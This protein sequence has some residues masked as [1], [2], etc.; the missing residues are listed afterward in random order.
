MGAIASQI[1]SFTVVYSIVY[2]DADQRKYESSTSLAFVLA[3][4]AGKPVT[5]KIFTFQIDW[6]LWTRL[7]GLKIS[8][9]SYMIVARHWKRS[10]TT[11][12]WFYI[13]KINSYFLLCCE[14]N[15]YNISISTPTSSLKYGCLSFPLSIKLSILSLLSV[16]ITWTVTEYTRWTVVHKTRCEIN[17]MVRICMCF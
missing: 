12:G 17:S 4:C 11:L 3:I 9:R 10:V 1:T 5:R 8:D 2:S 7:S 14:T 6:K 13:Q 15:I 16:F